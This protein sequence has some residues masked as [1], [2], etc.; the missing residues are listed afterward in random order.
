MDPWVNSEGVSSV[1]RCDPV[2]RFRASQRCFFDNA[3][4][5]HSSPVPHSPAGEFRERPV[6]KG[7]DIGLYETFGPAVKNPYFRPV[8]QGDPLA[9]VNKAGFIPNRNFRHSAQQY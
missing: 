1:F 6:F 7:V 3:R 4:A 5:M 2:E 8:L 9:A